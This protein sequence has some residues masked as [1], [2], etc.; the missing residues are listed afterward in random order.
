MN[1]VLLVLN[2]LL[3]A[4][5]YALG[6]VAGEYGLAPL[7]LLFWQVA[8]SA[9]V[10]LTTTWVAGQPPSLAPAFLRY[11]AVAGLLGL[12]LPYLVTYVVLAH[13]PAGI[14][15]IAVSLS[16]LMTYAIARVMRLERFH[17]ARMAGLALGFLGVLVIVVPKGALP[18]ADMA[19]WVLVALAAPLSLAG[20]NV[21]RSVAWPRG[22]RPL[23]MAAGMLATQALLIAPFA[24]ATGAIPRP[25]SEPSAVNVVLIGIALLSSA[26]Y[27][28][29]FELQRRA[30]PV[31]ISQLGYV[32]SLGTLAIGVLALGER[33]SAWV[34]LS[35]LAMTGGIALV[36]RAGRRLET[37]NSSVNLT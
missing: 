3:I 34:W 13:I 15:G 10:L 18:S 7:G 20:G 28:S 36:T 16:A 26:F 19:G 5:T 4:A 6:K 9:A 35:V 22:G 21:Y 14:L 30:G 1:T 25:T 11:Y 33:P 31:F 2:G 17:P 23:A 8:A 37:S 32:I 24:V 29:A 27:L 12:T